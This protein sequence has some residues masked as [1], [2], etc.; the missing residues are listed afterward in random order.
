MLSLLTA[1]NSSFFRRGKKYVHR[2]IAWSFSALRTISNGFFPF[3]SA[4]N[5]HNP[6]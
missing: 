2:T 6:L 3:Y 5:L 1:R 4:A